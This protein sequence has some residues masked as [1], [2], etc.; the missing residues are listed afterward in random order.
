M[1][2][3]TALN[4]QAKTEMWLLNMLAFVSTAFII[5]GANKYFRG[6]P[7]GIFH[8]LLE[9][10][11]FASTTVFYRTLSLGCFHPNVFALFR[12]KCPICVSSHREE[13]EKYLSGGSLWLTARNRKRLP[14]DVPR[15]PFIIAQN[16]TCASM[17]LLSIKRYET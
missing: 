8:I 5:F 2:I 1:V 4:T 15:K 7:L 17:R 9:F 11:L 10:R 6:L 14:C 12:F 3:Y 16:A 13:S